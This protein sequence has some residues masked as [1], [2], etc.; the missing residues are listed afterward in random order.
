MPLLL[1]NRWTSSSLNCSRSIHSICNRVETSVRAVSHSPYLGYVHV[2]FAKNRSP[3]RDLTMESSQGLGQQFE[4][5]ILCTALRMT[6]SQN[7]I[8]LLVWKLCIKLCPLLTLSCRGSKCFHWK[9][10]K[11]SLPKIKHQ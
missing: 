10:L 7:S 1:E 11:Q 5:S 6:H 2:I 3:S 4:I 8:I 9:R